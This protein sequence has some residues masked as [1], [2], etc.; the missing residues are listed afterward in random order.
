MLLSLG[1]LERVYEIYACL[2]H[3]SPFACA[4]FLLG[5]GPQVWKLSP[6]N[7]YYTKSWVV[8]RV[9]GSGNWITVN[10]YLWEKQVW[11]FNCVTWV[12]NESETG[13]P[14]NGRGL[15]KDKLFPSALFIE[16][17]LSTKY[18]QFWLLH[19]SHIFPANFLYCTFFVNIPQVNS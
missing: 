19:R 6:I 4:H 13:M 8:R 7:S 1:P 5:D 2:Q 9:D 11:T 15:D 12:N 10:K 3:N 18:C 14:G 16:P 17:L